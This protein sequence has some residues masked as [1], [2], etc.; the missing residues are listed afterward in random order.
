[1][2]EGNQR[3]A[4]PGFFTG[5]RVRGGHTGGQRIP[6]ISVDIPNSRLDGDISVI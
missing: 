1:M 2:P 6:D 4:A 5:S 3:A